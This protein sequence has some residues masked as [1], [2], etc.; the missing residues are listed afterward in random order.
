[1]TNNEHSRSGPGA[2]AGA[3]GGASG[4]R[5]DASP[6]APAGDPVAGTAAPGDTPL[7]ME[8]GQEYVAKADHDTVVEQL[9]AERESMKGDLQRV[10]ADFENYK[11]RALRE[12]EQASAA[13][14]TKLLGEL[15]TVIDEM[16]RATAHAEEAASSHPKVAEGIKSV[17]ARLE[18]IV[19][20]HG[21]ERVDTSGAFDANLHD[22][23]MVQPDPT[24]EEGAILQVL[25]S[26]WMLGERVLRHARVIVAGGG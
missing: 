23:M 10:A 14:E 16:E 26:G 11:R 24:A 19:R 3:W 20:A 12:R 6:A 18:A 25:E 22:A 9:T 5:P 8:P 17:H 21:L 2:T 13:A 4:L 7:P 15:L 1:M